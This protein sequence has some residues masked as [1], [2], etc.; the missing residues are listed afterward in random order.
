MVMKFG[1]WWMALRFGRITM[2]PYRDDVDVYRT[3]WIM[4]VARRELS[5]V[6]LLR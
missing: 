5:I 3:L 4:F 6:P 1:V 2:R